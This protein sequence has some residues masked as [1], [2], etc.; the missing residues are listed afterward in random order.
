MNYNKN[1]CV[2]LVDKLMVSYE[3]LEDVLGRKRA[4]QIYD[5]HALLSELSHSSKTGNATFR[6]A[7]RAWRKRIMAEID[8][9]G[10]YVERR[11]DEIVPWGLG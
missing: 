2:E 8:R 5:E 11:A 4:E 9:N 3:S 6:V 7:I 10:C 1:E